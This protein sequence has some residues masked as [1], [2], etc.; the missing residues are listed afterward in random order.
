MTNVL[1]QAQ[2][3]H[4]AQQWRLHAPSRN[5][6]ILQVEQMAQQIISGARDAQLTALMTNAWNVQTPVNPGPAILEALLGMLPPLPAP[7]VLP[8][9]PTMLPPAFPGLPYL[10]SDNAHMARASGTLPISPLFPIAPHV[11]SQRIQLPGGSAHHQ[12]A[13]ASGRHGNATFSYG[14]ST[15]TGNWSNYPLVP[16]T[17]P[18][19][20]ALPPAQAFRQQP[21][22]RVL[23]SLPAA[24]NPQASNSIL[25][26][27]QPRISAAHPSRQSHRET[28]SAPQN[29]RLHELFEQQLNEDG[30]SG[31][32]MDVEVTD[33]GVFHDNDF[34]DDAFPDADL[35]DN[36]FNENT[37]QSNNFNTNDLNNNDIDYDEYEYDIPEHDDIAHD[38]YREDNHHHDGHSD[39]PDVLYLGH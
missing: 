21:M 38:S 18:A 16:A 2:R 24:P 28:N 1:T 26:R 23:G 7:V 27:G 9:P 20:P 11:T 30:T 13:Q 8:L 36:E 4:L 5:V 34:H 17:V 35:L 3:L 15:V 22:G 14:S 6:P 12:S 29:A 25:Q 32:P 33:H 19:I 39:D 10:E 31:E 37:T